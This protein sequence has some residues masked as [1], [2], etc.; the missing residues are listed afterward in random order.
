MAGNE[1]IPEHIRARLSGF[2]EP[3]NL[4][5][6]TPDVSRIQAAIRQAE[7]GDTYQLFVF[8]RDW[9]LGSSHLQSELNKRKLVVV[10]QTYTV[11]PAD[12][13]NLNDVKACDYI[14][15]MIDNCENWDAGI[16]NLLD[17]A[18]WPVAVNE[19]LF[20]PAQ[21][22]AGAK[23]PVRHDLKFFPVNT[24][25][26]C[27]KIPYLAPG[28]FGFGIAEPAPNSIPI[29]SRSA[30]GNPF[31]TAWNP[32]IWEPDLRF[33]SVYE[34][35]MVDRSWA[36]VYAADPDRHIVHRGSMLNGI[37]D[38]YG[39][40]YRALWP[41][42]FLNTQ[43]RDWWGRG[44]ER[45]GAPFT[46]INADTADSNTVNLLQQALSNCTKL[47]GLV[48][49][50]GAEA[51]LI[52]I[53][54]TDMAQAYQLLHQTCNDEIS[55][56]ITGQTTGETQKSNSG[57]NSGTGKGVQSD[58]QVRK[59][60][61]QFDK[62]MLG[63]TLRRQLFPQYLAIN[64]IQGDCKIVWG[65]FDEEGA[66]A[67]ADRLV[68][69]KAAGFMPSKAAHEHISEKLGMPVERYEEPKDDGQPVEK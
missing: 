32:D 64:G 40:V 46:K 27:Y 39:G 36:G 3:P 43:V 14:K 4:S 21:N 31:D 42:I 57:L 34:N 25:L 26:F 24:T 61:Q 53:S 49:P 62:T 47:F 23:R 12:K 30:T 6:V 35:G 16:S 69:Q 54:H 19:K 13:E 67:F 2:G 5:A 45:Y 48:L 51:E 50:K 38:N 22:R 15:D 65:G 68:K 44:T 11:Q 8:Y 37:R 33:Y 17:A 60:Y 63:N 7:R 41:W 9:I 28:G 55:K 52:N 56:I 59:D 66:S 20:P 10:G 58:T 1:Q 29:G 18:I